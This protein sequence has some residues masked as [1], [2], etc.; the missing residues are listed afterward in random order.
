[1]S[2]PVNKLLIV[3][4]PA[5]GLEAVEQQLH[6]SGM[7]GP[8]PSRREAMLPQQIA[9]LLLKAH[10]CEPLADITEESA[11]SSLE[12]APIWNGIALD[13]MLGNVD[14]PFWGW[15]DPAAIFFL[16]YWREQDPSLVFVLV[17][18]HPSSALLTLGAVADPLDSLSHRASRAIDNWL[19][20]NSALLAFH[21]RNGSRSVLISREQAEQRLSAYL[22]ELGGKLRRSITPPDDAS[23]KP[24][25][26]APIPSF[27]PIADLVPV[28][29]VDRW[30]AIHVERYLLDQWLFEQPQAMELYEQLLAASSVSPVRAIAQAPVPRMA[31]EALL[32]H[33]QLVNHTLQHVL[34][35]RD[36]AQQ[37]L[38]SLQ[39]QSQRLLADST[40]QSASHQ[41]A[42]ATTQG[43]LQ[44]LEQENE[45]LLQ[46]LHQVQE[47][48]EK[49]FL[50]NQDRKKKIER[51]Q[52][53][54]AELCKPKIYGAAERI[55]Q[56]LTYRLGVRV[57]R[58]TQTFW[59]AIFLFQALALELYFFRLDQKAESRK[60]LPPITAYAD[61]EAA[62]AVKK[63]LAYRLG[64]VVKRIGWNPLKWPLLPFA[65]KK[66]H[67]AWLLER[68][69]A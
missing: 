47:E 69:K 49:Y 29:E 40:A 48:L 36:Q 9:A 53:E 62:E 5:S 3:G 25:R 56:Q 42:L 63:H 21:L 45:L 23:D 31:W 60:S 37:S 35:L 14:Q 64:L 16:D 17:Y 26:L 24:L 39:A 28:T 30:Q 13:L 38:S 67:R 20:Y 68:G 43:R 66:E 32:Q 7:A 12:V 22:G 54:I 65:L 27:T 52:A 34:S 57:L 1:M 55:K 19:A 58:Q 8:R 18:D 46:Q 6:A 11:F 10:G 4:H 59:D 51:L 50:E 33:R 41:Q 61:A 44:E 15:A 2:N